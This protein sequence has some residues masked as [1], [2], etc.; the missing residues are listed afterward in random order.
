MI[1]NEFQ[2]SLWK[3]SE[4]VGGTFKK[5]DFHIHMPGSSDYEYTGGD[6]M[7]LLAEAI[8]KLQY[9]FVIVLEH[10]KFPD[11]GKVEALQKLCPNTCIIP[12]AEINV[13]V[14]ALFKKVGKDY[15][16]HC[17][18]AVNPKQAIKDYNYILEDAKKNLGYR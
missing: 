8:N 3:N 16:F 5:A 11:L 13:F 18:V 1:V 6:A 15:Y 2:K 12:G 10:Q 17:I 9:S 7:E 4:N 14:D